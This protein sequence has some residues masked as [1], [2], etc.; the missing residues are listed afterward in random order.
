MFIPDQF[1]VKGKLWKVKFIHDLREDHE[2]VSGVCDTDKRVIE[3]DSK[4]RSTKLRLTFLHELFHALAFESHTTDLMSDDLEE[5]L[6]D[7]FADLIETSF[8]QLE[9]KEE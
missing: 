6:A 7:S 1:K 4:L 9:W 3:L 5:V 8:E 2:K